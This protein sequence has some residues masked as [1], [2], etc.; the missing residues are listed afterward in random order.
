[1]IGQVTEQMT[2]QMEGQKTE[3]DAIKAKKQAASQLTEHPAEHPTE[4]NSGQI[5]GRI[6]EQVSEQVKKQVSEQ[7]KEQVIIQKSVADIEKAILKFCEKPKSRQ[8]IQEYLGFKSRNNLIYRYIRPL[9]K[10]G[11]LELT[12]P[13]KPHSQNQ[14]YTS[15]S[16][17]KR[18]KSI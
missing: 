16:I 18:K 14:K 6:K 17:K 13:D 3:L 7:V 4:Q 1:M 9:L 2:E 10:K 8:E 15:K 11:K 5:S 12:I